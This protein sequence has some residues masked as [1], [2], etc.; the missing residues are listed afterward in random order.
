MIEENTAFE[1]EVSKVK[2]Y[3]SPG[4]KNA[5]HRRTLVMQREV[6][7]NF[8]LDKQPLRSYI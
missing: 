7:F 5:H 8:F 3:S 2:M 6:F 4:H 1:L